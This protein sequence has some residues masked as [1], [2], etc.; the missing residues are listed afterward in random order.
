MAYDVLLKT[1]PQPKIASV[2]EVI[3]SYPA[4]GRLYGKVAS[5]L[6]P[7]MANATVAVALWHGTTW[8]TKRRMWM[9]RRAFI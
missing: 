1:L 7:A 8:N 4:V 5:G 6:G 9:R 3:A 2:R